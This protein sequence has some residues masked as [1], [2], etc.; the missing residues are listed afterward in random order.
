[1]GKAEIPL[2]VAETFLAAEAI[3]L[4][5]GH[6]FSAQGTIANQIPDLSVAVFVARA[7]HRAPYLTGLAFAVGQAT[8]V[9]A[10]RV[11]GKTQAVELGF[12]SK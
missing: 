11:A 10:P 3:T 12:V 7:T 5:G 4:F 8:E 2:G 6:P 1:L 9:T